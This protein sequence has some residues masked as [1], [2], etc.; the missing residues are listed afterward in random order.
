MKIAFVL[1]SGDTL[2]DD[3]ARA[4]AIVT[5][6]LW[7]AA[8]H[9]GRD[10]DGLLDH[11]CTMHP[12]KM[13]GWV[14]ERRDQGRPDAGMLWRPQHKQP[15]RNLTMQN[16][17]SWGGS[18]GLLCVT[19]ALM[20]CDASHVVLCGVPLEAENKHYD[21]TRRVWAE[22]PRY[23]H[24]WVKHQEKMRVRVRS[25]SGWTRQLLGDPTEEWLNAQ[26]RAA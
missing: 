5:P 11:W 24:A 13:A 12:E 3:L 6:D 17:P 20:F 10:H 22:A 2:H 18:S 7:L 25:M 21:D 26:Q 8:N 9:A 19:V 15:G 1:G 23:R 16:A 14:Q 4:L